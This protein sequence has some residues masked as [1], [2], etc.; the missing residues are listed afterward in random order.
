MKRNKKNI[1]RIQLR[2]IIESIL[3]EQFTIPIHSK[4]SGFQMYSESGEL[5]EIYASQIGDDPRAEMGGDPYG[6]EEEPEPF[7]YTEEDQ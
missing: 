7:L 1:T 6:D 3:L 2:R 5:D 4:H